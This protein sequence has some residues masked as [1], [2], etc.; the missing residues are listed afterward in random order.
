MLPST[1]SLLITMVAKLSFAF[2]ITIAFNSIQH[3]LPMINYFHLLKLQ[4]S[5]KT[6][7][8]FETYIL[9]SVTQ[10]TERKV[11]QDDGWW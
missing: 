2:N 9:T 1:L 10:E 11:G 4:I 7:Q 6:N 3:L 8:C 5:S